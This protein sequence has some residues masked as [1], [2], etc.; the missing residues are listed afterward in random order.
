MWAGQKVR[1]KVACHNG[2]TEDGIGGYCCEPGDVLIIRAI[3]DRNSRRFNWDY[4]VSHEAITDNSFGVNDYEIEPHNAKLSDPA[5]GTLGKP[6]HH[7]Q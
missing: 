4:W 2:L 7:G 6:E 5:T 3:G 1:A